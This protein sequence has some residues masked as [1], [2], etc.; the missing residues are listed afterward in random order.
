MKQAVERLLQPSGVR[1]AWRLTTANQGKEAFSDLAVLKFE[2]R[3]RAEAP[4]AASAFGSLGETDTLAST[5][6]SHGRVLPYTRVECDE[7]RKALAYVSP[8]AG[9]LQLKEALGLALGR[10]VAHELYHILARTSSHASEGLAKTSQM[11]RDLVS[12]HEL[13]FDETAL[14]AIRNRFLTK[15]QESAGGLAAGPVIRQN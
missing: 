11:L 6:I 8:G 5:A 13:G 9:T 12:T 4:R 10:V 15:K 2:G 7:V 14:R 1:L 3:C